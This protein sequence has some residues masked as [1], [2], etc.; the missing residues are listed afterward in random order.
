[1]VGS[2][3]TERLAHEI[4]SAD[5]ISIETSGLIIELTFDD[6]LSGDG[7]NNILNQNNYYRERGGDALSL[8]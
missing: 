2:R 4:E 7:P 8:H 5:G 6:I 3:S 1:M